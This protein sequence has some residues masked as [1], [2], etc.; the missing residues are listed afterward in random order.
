MNRCFIWRLLKTEVCLVCSRCRCGASRAAPSLG[1]LPSTPLPAPGWTA[2]QDG[3]GCTISKVYLIFGLVIEFAKKGGQLVPGVMLGFLMWN[4]PNGK[5]AHTCLQMALT[6][7]PSLFLAYGLWKG[8]LLT[9]FSHH[10]HCPYLL[11]S[12]Y[13]FG[14]VP[15]IR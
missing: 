9:F 1:H 11:R 5:L 3:S 10:S 7:L 2:L 15:F 12:K 14:T 6:S 4:F 13:S 8:I